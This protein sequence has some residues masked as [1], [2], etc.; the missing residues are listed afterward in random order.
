MRIGVPSVKQQRSQLDCRRT[1]YLVDSAMRYVASFSAI[2]LIA[3]SFLRITQFII[4]SSK[5]MLMI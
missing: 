1:K 3:I 5:Y 4:L 2:Y